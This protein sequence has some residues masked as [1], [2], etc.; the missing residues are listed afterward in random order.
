M[1]LNFNQ[2]ATE[3]NTFLKGYAKDLN[4]GNDKEKAG[5]ILTAVLH[6]LREIIPPEESLQLIAQFPMFL[7][8]VYVN[9]WTLKSKR[10]KIKNITEFIDLVR[11]FDGPASIY[12]FESDELAENY[13][14][15]TFISLRKYISLGELE[16]I[17]TGL[18]KDLKPLIYHSVMF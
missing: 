18:P 10:E 17:R 5:R 14:Q 8:A 4:L 13:I 6:T 12:D 11:S 1:A 15:T 16:D 2:Y 9:G 3:A 7:K